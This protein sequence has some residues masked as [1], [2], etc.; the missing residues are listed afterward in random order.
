MCR[1]PPPSRSM[2]RGGASRTRASLPSPAGRMGVTGPPQ[3]EDAHGPVVM[4][5]AKAGAVQMTAAPAPSGRTRRPGQGPGFSHSGAKL[6]RRPGRQLAADR[7]RRLPA[8]LVRRDADIPAQPVIQRG[9]SRRERRSAIASAR[10]SLSRRGL[11]AQ[12]HADRSHRNGG[13]SP[14]IHNIP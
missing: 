13:H 2:R 11:M 8:S 7:S 14:T 1:S 5:P 12:K 3:R 6:G 9:S 10:R 4:S